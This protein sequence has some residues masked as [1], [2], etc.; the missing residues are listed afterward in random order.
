MLYVPC[1]TF[2]SRTR[3]PNRLGRLPDR[4]LD[5]VANSRKQEDKLHVRLESRIGSVSPAAYTK[6]AKTAEGTMGRS[7]VPTFNIRSRERCP[8][9]VGRVPER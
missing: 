8:N 5:P 4:L 7:N 3:L 6:H 9:C 2:A 1:G